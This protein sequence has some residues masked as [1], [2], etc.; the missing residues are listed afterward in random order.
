MILKI[1]R[2]I[3]LNSKDGREMVWLLKPSE[4]CFN[5]VI[6]LRL[7]LHKQ[8]LAETILHELYVI[9]VSQAC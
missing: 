4:A 3:D 9:P 7:E 8:A 1:L 5:V 6:I 2:N